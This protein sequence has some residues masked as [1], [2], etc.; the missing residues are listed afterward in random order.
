[1]LALVLQFAGPAE[2]ISLEKHLVKSQLICT[3]NR[4]IYFVR[5][6]IQI[7]CNIDFQENGLFGENL[8]KSTK[9]VVL[10]LAPWYDPR[11]KF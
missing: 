9:I 1:M 7:V 10:K 6:N 2:S 5:M 3:R 11:G 4:A 8:S